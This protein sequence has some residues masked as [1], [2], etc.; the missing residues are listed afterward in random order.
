MSFQR[1]TD[2]DFWFKELLIQPKILFF[3]LL[4]ATRAANV[5]RLQYFRDVFFLETKDY[6]PIMMCMSFIQ[7][8]SAPFWSFIAEKIGRP[9]LILLFIAVMQ[10]A[11]FA[12]FNLV[13]P[14]VEEDRGTKSGLTLVS[15]LIALM[16]GAMQ[17]LM[18]RICL[19]MFT[20]AG[21]S[22]E[23]YGKQR[24]FGSLG[25]LLSS[26]IIANLVGGSRYDYLAYSVYFTGALFFVMGLIFLPKDIPSKFKTQKKAPINEEKP[27]FFQGLSKSFSDIGR[28]FCNLNYMTLLVIAVINGV[29]RAV[30][31]HYFGGFMED[32]VDGP[33]VPKDI[34]VWCGVAG[35]VFEM[36]FFFLS[37]AMVKK[38]GNF[39][40]MIMAQI[41]MFTRW[42]V[43][44]SIPRGK[45][46]WRMVFIGIIGE[47]FKGISFGLMMA[48]G[49]LVA[50]K[51]APLELQ[52]TAQGFFQA[53]YN[54]AAPAL[55]GMLGSIIIDND[56]IRLKG[57]DKKSESYLARRIEKL[58]TRGRFFQDYA[59]LFR[60]S[61]ILSIVALFLL[62]LKKFL[63][64]SRTPHKAQDIEKTAKQDDKFKDVTLKVPEPVK[65]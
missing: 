36:C 53:M 4:C 23:L 62:I 55:A 58:S 3:A 59:G 31:S 9:K 5:Y 60:L 14:I 29:C 21:L 25:D 7:L 61:A 26:L 56:V 10:S 8:I 38:Y 37:T 39:N 54:G 20:D 44:A 49:V 63:D 48:S 65:Q 45:N 50:A 12:I 15:M 40:L 30:G 32:V 47:S 1:F 42:A 64:K 16:T 34:M 35:Y 2:R 46:D 17:P 33:G 22:R 51:E 43:N 18:D 52:T 57:E 24:L 19:M 13:P 27:S 6:G 28:L 41:A 11:S